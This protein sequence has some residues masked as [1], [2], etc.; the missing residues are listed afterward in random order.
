M[1][2]HTAN[3]NKNENKAQTREGCKKVDNKL[4]RGKIKLQ[5]ICCNKNNKKKREMQNK[6]KYGSAGEG[7]GRESDQERGQR[8]RVATTTTKYIVVTKAEA[9]LGFN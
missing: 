6:I 7:G 8:N 4:K 1:K 3:E 5:F 2:T 9:K